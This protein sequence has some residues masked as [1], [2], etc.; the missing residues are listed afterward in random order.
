MNAEDDMDDKV[1]ECCSDADVFVYVANGTATFET[2]VSLCKC[3][4]ACVDVLY[5]TIVYMQC[6]LTPGDLWMTSIPCN[7]FVFSCSRSYIGHNIYI[8][9]IRTLSHSVLIPVLYI[10]S[11]N[12]YLYSLY[13]YVV[14][15]MDVSA[16]F[17]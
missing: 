11:F 9:N 5:S 10:Y 16:P 7:Y 13:T 4:Y 14:C 17:A 15:A 12:I 6:C 3:M 1:I 2:T 8:R